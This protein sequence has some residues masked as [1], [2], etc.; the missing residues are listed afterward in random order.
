MRV[1]KKD[2]SEEAYNERVAGYNQRE[3]ELRAKGKNKRATRYANRKANKEVRMYERA[4]RQE[5]KK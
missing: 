1:K 5:S 4:Q 2:V 3:A